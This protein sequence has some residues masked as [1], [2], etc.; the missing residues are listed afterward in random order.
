MSNASQ[1]S[2]KKATQTV[3]I[4]GLINVLNN[5][6]CKIDAATGAVTALELRLRIVAELVPEVQIELSKNTKKRYHEAKL[7]DLIPAILATFQNE[8]DPAER[9]QIEN[10]RPPRNKLSHGSIVEFMLEVNGEAPGRQ[11][12]LH[13]RKGNPL[14]KGN[15]LE[16]ALS[17]DKSRGLEEFCKRAKEAISIID[18]K[19]LSI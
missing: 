17:I 8:L 11:L 16:G 2:T 9:I 4:G 7:H 6:Q 13:T 3:P 12:D 14:K 18:S 5:I 15:L 1:L 10:C 19:I